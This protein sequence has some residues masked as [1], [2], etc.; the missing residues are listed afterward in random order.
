MKTTLRKLRIP[1]FI[2]VVTAVVG[3]YPEPVSLAEAQKYKSSSSKKGIVI[4]RVLAPRPSNFEAGRWLILQ[5]LSEGTYPGRTLR[6]E[7]GE[8]GWFSV[9]LEPGT[10]CLL[11]YKYRK[12]IP[13]VRTEEGTFRINGV[14]E[15][16]ESTDGYVGTFVYDAHGEWAI[17]DESELAA[18][19][20]SKAFPSHKGQLIT[21]LSI[22][23]E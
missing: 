19:R 10:Y 1:L 3:C 11:S 5:R 7:I 8:E 2:S 22:L 16:S 12:E 23:K 21:Q 4:G 18:V 15:K 17:K 20:L 14:F 13:T 6:V 9:F